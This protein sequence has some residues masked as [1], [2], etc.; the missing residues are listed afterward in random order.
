M[1]IFSFP[2][3]LIIF[4]FGAIIGSFLNVV[5]YRYNT[6]RTL[7]GRSICMSCGKS[8][9]WF[10]LIPVISWLVQAGKCVRCRSVIPFQYPLVEAVTGLLFLGVVRMYVGLLP[11]TTLFLWHVIPAVFLWC[12]LVVIAVY[13]IRH[14]IIPDLFVYLFIIISALLLFVTPH[15]F[16]VPP[17]LILGGGGGWLDFFAGFIIPLP[18]ALLWYATGGRMIGFGD[19]K[20]MMGIGFFLGLGMGIAAVVLA[21]WVGALVGVFLLLTHGKD[22]TM[23]TQIPFGPFLILGIVIAYFCQLSFLDI[24]SWLTFFT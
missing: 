24:A 23:K 9:R 6:G 20:L 2:A 1:I 11:D 16:V 18:F 14:K 4:L 19:I 13:D 10:E 3:Q 17:L 12:M 8:L 22:V 15:G 21:F 5:I 7:G